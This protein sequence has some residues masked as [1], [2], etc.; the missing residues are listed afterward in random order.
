MFE[1]GYNTGDGIKSSEYY[2]DLHGI[3]TYTVLQTVDEVNGWV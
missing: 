1:Y 2:L 3:R